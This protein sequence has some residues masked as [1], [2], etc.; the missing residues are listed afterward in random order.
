MTDLRDQMRRKMEWLT[1]AMEGTAAWLDEH[2]VELAGGMEPKENIKKRSHRCIQE[3][4][5]LLEEG[6]RHD[7]PKRKRRGVC[8]TKSK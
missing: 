8:K 3:V 5:A 7:L 6:M 2:A 1:D 4:R